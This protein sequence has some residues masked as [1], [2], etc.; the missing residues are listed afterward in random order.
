MDITTDIEPLSDD[1]S[2]LG[3]GLKQLSVARAQINALRKQNEL[4][5]KQLNER[6]VIVATKHSP[7]DSD[8]IEFSVIG[9]VKT[10]FKER[11]CVPRQPGLCP[12]AQAK[13]TILNTI[14]TNPSHALEGLADFSHMWVLFHF[15]KNETTH[16]H[17]KVSPPRLNGLKTG[18]L[19]TRSPHRPSPIGLSLV[20]IDKVEDMIDGTPVIDIKPYIPHYDAPMMLRSFNQSISLVDNGSHQILLDPLTANREDPDGEETTCY[21][22]MPLSPLHS[23]VRVPQWITEPLTQELTVEFSSRAR[24]FLDGLNTNDIEPT[25][26]NI[27]KEDPRSVY[28]RERYSNQFYTFLIG[29]FHISCKFDN[30]KH[31]VNVYRISPVDNLD[32]NADQEGAQCLS[33]N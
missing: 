6:N 18:V 17:A 25:I 10:K 1:V 33:V 2:D 3:E 11:R 19:G 21:D 32:S 8:K 5:K 15:H 27:L 30:S 28:V 31:S 20:Q 16:V 9:V 14:F 12:L 13:L 7:K 22:N 4:L 24:E 29:G 23:K 26:V